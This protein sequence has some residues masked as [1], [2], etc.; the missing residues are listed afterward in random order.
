MSQAGISRRFPV[1]RCHRRVHG[2]RGHRHRAAAAQGPPWAQ[3]FHQQHRHRLGDQG[4]VL[5]ATR[6]GELFLPGAMETLCSSVLSP[7]KHTHRNR[8]R[9]VTVITWN[10][11]PLHKTFLDKEHGHLPGHCVVLEPTA[12]TGTARAFMSTRQ[13]GASLYSCPLLMWLLLS[14]LSECSG[15]RATSSSDAP[16]SYSSSPRGSS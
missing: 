3:P 9:L 12:W 8:H 14:V 2:R 11:A 7:H 15:T 1:T 10:N 6:P 13:S 4:C 5:G 16:S